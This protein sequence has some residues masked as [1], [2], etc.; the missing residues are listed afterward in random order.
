MEKEASNYAATSAHNR[1]VVYEKEAAPFR[2]N[3]CETVVLAGTQARQANGEKE[4]RTSWHMNMN[5]IKHKAAEARGCAAY[6][7]TAQFSMVK[8][9]GRH[10]AKLIIEN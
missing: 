1:G 4:I 8:I 3:H 7:S 6:V 10:F 5:D 9:V 2:N